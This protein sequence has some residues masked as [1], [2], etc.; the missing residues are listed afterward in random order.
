MFHY[1]LSIVLCT[2]IA[3]GIGGIVIAYWRVT[4]SS[5]LELMQL[6]GN[7]FIVVALLSERICMHVFLVAA[8][9]DAQQGPK[10]ICMGVLPK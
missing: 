5:L 1:I 10:F 9:C 4:H 6:D 8:S 3:V 7:V 2:T